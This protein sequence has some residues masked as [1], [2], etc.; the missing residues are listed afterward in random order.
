MR[1]TTIILYGILGGGVLVGGRARRQPRPRPACWS[2]LLAAAA[3]AGFGLFVLAG[4][5]PAALGLLADIS[6][7]FP[8]DRGAIMG[9]YSVFLAVGQI[10]GALIGGFAA[11]AARHRRDAH[12]DGRRSLAVALLPAAPSLRRRRGVA[13]CTGADRMTDGRPVDPGPARPR[14]ARRRRRAASPR[15]GGRARTSCG[16]GGS[17]VDAAIATNAVLGVVMPS[18]CGIGGDAFWLIWDAAAGAQHALNG[19]GRRRPPP[20]PR[21]SA[22]RGLH[23]APATRAAVDHG[24]G[25]GPLV[26]RR[27]RPLRP[28]VARRDPGP[29]HRAGTGRLPGLGRVHRRGRGDGAARG[30]GA[31]SGRRASAPSTGRTA[32]RGARASGSACR[33]SPAT[34]DTL[35]A[36]ASTPSTTATSASGRR[37]AWPRPARRSRA[38]DL[39]AH[40]LDLGRADRDRLPR[41]PRHDPPAQQLG[42][43]RARAARPSSARFEPPRARPRSGRTASPTRAGSTSASRRP[44]SRWPIA[45]RT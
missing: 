11:D 43:R 25:R 27:A 18:G 6:E 7:R 39:R 36:T 13:R 1:R 3:V 34:L 14:V 44:S 9:L 31:R 22:P 24:P 15:D 38:A 16:P 40:T 45:T 12:R 30:A 2:S 5:T 42:H 41:R 21:R 32:G 29:G 28:A 10:I 19:S 8:N 17:A 4:A 35:A 26:G 33:P 20:T 37:A 23:G